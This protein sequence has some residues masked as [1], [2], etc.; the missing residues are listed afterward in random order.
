[1]T[2]HAPPFAFTGLERIFHE[3]ARLGIVT[4]LASKRDGVRFSD[5]KR[6]CGLTDGNLNRHLQALDAAGFVMSSRESHETRSLTR[7]HL[8]DLGRERF[9]A[10]LSA[11]EDA[12]REAAEA[13]ESPEIGLANQRK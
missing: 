5:L 7:Y 6:L 9:L 2:D 8:T 1:M 13:A 10:Y 11:L 4:S 12:L 3:P